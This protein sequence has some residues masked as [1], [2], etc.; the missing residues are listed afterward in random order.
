MAT[1]D[2][3]NPHCQQLMRSAGMDFDV[4]RFKDNEKKAEAAAATATVASA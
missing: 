2:H 1:E 4:H 3:L